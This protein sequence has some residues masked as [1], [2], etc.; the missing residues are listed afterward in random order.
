MCVDLHIHSL[1]S[2]G[3]ASPAELV[4]MA[5]ASGLTGIALTDHDTIEGIDEFLAHGRTHELELIPGFEINATHRDFSLHLTS[6]H[7]TNRGKT[8]A[9]MW[10]A[11]WCCVN[12]VLERH[13]K[14]ES[15][16]LYS[17][18]ALITSLSPNWTSA[19]NHRQRHN[20]RRQKITRAQPALRP[21]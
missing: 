3:T 20:W 17:T 21:A 19:R 13:G 2:D 5:V 10:S 7:C 6:I 14:S 1:Y 18:A 15:E 4:R 16:V 12:F 11:A 8:V 9:T